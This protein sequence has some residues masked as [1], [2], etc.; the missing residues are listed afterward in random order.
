MKLIRVVPHTTIL[1]A[2]RSPGRVKCLPVPAVPYDT[3]MVDVEQS[4]RL[5]LNYLGACDPPYIGG[6][7]EQLSYGFTTVM[8]P[9]ITVSVYTVDEETSVRIR[10]DHLLFMEARANLFK[11]ERKF[12]NLRPTKDSELKS[13]HSVTYDE[14]VQAELFVRLEKLRY[15]LL[16]TKIPKNR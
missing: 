11:R 4:M 1:R 15:M 9:L 14:Q 7:V 5:T 2:V 13:T 10:T 6:K 16:T 12:V 3:P 8:W